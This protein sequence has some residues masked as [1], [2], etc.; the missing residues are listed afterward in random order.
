MGINGNPERKL[1]RI[2]FEL[3]A[4][5]FAAHKHDERGCDLIVCWEDDWPNCKIERLSLKSEIVALD[6]RVI[7]SPSRVK[8]R[9]ETWTISRFRIG[10]SQGAPRIS[11]LGSRAAWQQ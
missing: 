6:L 9:P 5:N 3:R 2:E 1:V 8:Y 4:S 11:R 10:P 7:Q